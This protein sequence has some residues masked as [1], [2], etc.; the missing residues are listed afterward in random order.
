MNIAY[1]CSDIFAPI[2]GVSILSLFENNKSFDEICVYIIERQ[3]QKS[4]QEKLQS[5][6]D[7]YERTIVFI[8]MEDINK[9]ENLQLE[10]VKEQ[11]VFDS[12]N[13]IFLD[14]ILPKHIEKVLYL[15][16]DVLITGDLQELW[17]MDMQEFC[18][19]AAS[20][21]FGEDY[22][23]L[24]GLSSTT[25]YCN[26][27]V[28]LIDLKEWRKREV[29]QRIKDYV[30]NN[31]GY[32]FFMEQTVLNAVLQDELLVLEPE[33]N[34]STM[35][36]TF[37]YKELKKLRSFKRFYTKDE[38]SEA[39]REPKIIH[40]TSCFMIPNRYWIENSTHP[41]KDI[42]QK[43]KAISPWSEGPDYPDSRNI[44]RKMID[45]LITKLPRKLVLSLAQKLHY[46]RIKSIRKTMLKVFN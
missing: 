16:S 7:K 42:Y 17:N 33:Y 30:A 15:D 39:V 37:T 38:V 18:A 11:W 31:N 41:A 27:G 12:Y 14:S 29:K 22:Y 44:K 5:I 43:Y 19:A 8:P 32:V 10:K 3:I 35:M 25:R 2:A 4:N 13:R 24:F 45:I 46:F 28:L 21:C 9:T 1:H 20:D 26:S 40:G 34:V 23:Q 36:M 6:A